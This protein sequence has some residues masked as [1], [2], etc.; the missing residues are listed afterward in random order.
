MPKKMRLK[1]KPSKKWS[2]SNIINFALSVFVGL[3]MVL[4]SVFAFAPQ[5]S[6]TAAPGA[7][8]FAF[9][10]YTPTPGGPTFTPTPLGTPMPTATPTR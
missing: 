1:Q 7:P 5:S 6:R 9:E 8:T 10:L 2:R 3:S 4:G